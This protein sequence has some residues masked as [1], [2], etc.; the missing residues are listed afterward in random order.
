MKKITLSFL[1][2]L[3]SLITV[4]AQG[5]FDDSI[6]TATNFGSVNSPGA[7][8]VQNVIDQNSNTKFLDF[9]AFDGIGFEVDLLGVSQTAIAM[10][11]VTAN[12]APERDPN[13]FEVFGSNDGTNYTSIATGSIPC[14]STRFFART[15]SFSNTNSY[16]Y[17]RV[18]FTGTCGTSSIN[19]IAD[20]Q[21]YTAI[22]DLPVLTCPSDITVNNT[23][24]QCT[25]NVTYTVTANDTEDG[26]LT[27]TLISGLA[28]GSDFPIGT[29][30][31]SYSVTDSD[32]NTV[33]CSFNV[34]VN[35]SENPVATCPS[36][37]MVDT[38]PGAATAVVNYS[39]SASDNCST[40][41]PLTGFTPLGTLNGKAYY[42]S[43]NAFT[44]DNAYTDA[45]NQGGFVGTIRN[46][47]DA[48]YLLNA[49]S[50]AGITETVLIG[51][52]DLNTEGT[53]VWHSG[54]AATYSNWNSGE[55]NNAGN[56]D[57][58][59]IETSGGWNDVN[60][61]NTY[62]YLLELN[63]APQQTAGLASG[64][65]FPIGTTTN[66]FVVTDVEG[67]SVTCSFDV[68]VNEVLSAPSFSLDTGI[69]MYP[70]PATHSLTL[71]NTS[72]VILEN[73]VIYDIN[74]RVISSTNFDSILE[75]KTIDVSSLTSG[76]YLVKIKGNSGSSTVKR[77]IKK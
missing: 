22:G 47:A 72:N 61:A 36:N 28:S 33:S 13:A 4:S 6:H 24:G 65:D 18:N 19:Q 42:V 10:E 73:A 51:Y 71:K 15:F 23:A 17:Y 32:N 45:V 58:T 20:V 2:L 39:V 11:M 49:M 52:N 40:I 14:V 64:S 9:D 35:D 27:P 21:L 12:D 57:Y 59:T 37:I 76:L 38:D 56:E 70:N 63:Y 54:D 69:T 74:G 16:T 67:N 60:T 1:L 55:P 8:G 30:V 46:S 43:D 25:G 3:F 75:D 29:T 77:F 44:A 26:T 48:T 50:M 62:K 34:T 31:V 66:T 53:F 68:I 41:N 7:E 5:I